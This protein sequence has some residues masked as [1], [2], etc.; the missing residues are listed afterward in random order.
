MDKGYDSEDVLRLIHEMLDSDSLIPVRNRKQK[1][2]FGFFRIGLA[3][4]FD[5][6]TYRQRSKVETVF[7]LIK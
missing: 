2:I 4:S 3:M 6:D 7:S 1:R 5:E